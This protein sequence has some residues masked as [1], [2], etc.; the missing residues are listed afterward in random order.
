M[1]TDI[2]DR[3]QAEERLETSHEQLRSLAAHLESVTE[4]ERKHIARELHDELGQMLTALK[5]DLSW[6]TPRLPK[7]QESLLEKTKSMC[8]LIDMAIHTV[9]KVSAELRPAVLDDLGVTAAIEWQAG[10]FEKLTEI[11]CEFSS[12]P[13]DVVLDQD[14]S[15]AIFRIFQEALTNVVR[16]ANATKVKASL[17]EEAGKIVLRIRD[18]G[19]GITKEQI[20]DPKAFGLIGI[21]ERAHFW[22]GEV[23]ISGT[24]GKG[25]TV[26]V[27]IPLMNEENHD[28]ESTNC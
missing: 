26:V 17:I 5:I 8:Q 19:K 13:E 25:T 9:Q 28:A 16:H 24:P 15:T 21:R 18:N 6:L 12:N 3:K 7:E 1:V 22:G 23:K 14:R 27:S 4:E 10:E 20:S 2:T 11:K